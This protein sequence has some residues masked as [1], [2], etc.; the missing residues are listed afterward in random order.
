MYDVEKR[1]IFFFIFQLKGEFL[2]QTFISHK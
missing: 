2:K 1:N